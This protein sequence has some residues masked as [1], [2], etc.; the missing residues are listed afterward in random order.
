VNSLLGRWVEVSKAW[1][2]DADPYIGLNIQQLGNV[3]L[4]ILDLE[5][6]SPSPIFGEPESI[7]EAFHR[8]KITAISN[9]WVLGLYEVM[10]LMSKRNPS[11]SIQFQALFEDVTIL[12]I[13]LAKHEPRRP[14]DKAKREA[15]KD[16]LHYPGPLGREG[17]FDSAWF[18]YDPSKE[19]HVVLSR[20]ELSRRFLD[21]AFTPGESEEN[22]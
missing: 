22:R 6:Q 10:R 17:T 18:P 3:E 8:T 19:Q 14:A 15:L 7:A 5:Q 9:L 1:F 12:R 16:K 13:P 2:I 21:G 11:P 20:S 4:V